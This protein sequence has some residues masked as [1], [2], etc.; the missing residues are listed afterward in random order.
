MV[1]FDCEMEYDPQRRYTQEEM[2]ALIRP[3]SQLLCFFAQASGYAHCVLGLDFDRY[4]PHSRSVPVIVMEGQEARP[5]LSVHGRRFKRAYQ[6]SRPGRS[7][8]VTFSSPG[9][10]GWF[11]MAWELDAGRVVRY[12]PER[13]RRYN[14]VIGY[15]L[16]DATYSVIGPPGRGIDPAFYSRREALQAAQRYGRQDEVH[17]VVALHL[18][19]VL[20]VVLHDV[21]DILVDGRT[22]QR[23]VRACQRRGLAVN[24]QV[25]R[26]VNPSVRETVYSC[27]ALLTV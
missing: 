15:L 2:V 6:A 18:D 24:A 14:P 25:C 11:Q 8:V 3:H 27:R 13:E 9:A 23:L 7:L 10:A 17:E 21:G 5:L 16:V 19:G 12:T 4:D 1:V 20:G 26:Q 22:A